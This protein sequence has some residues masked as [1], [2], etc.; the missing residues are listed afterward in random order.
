MLGLASKRKQPCKG[1]AL[2][3][4]AWAALRW[5][6][7]PCGVCSLS[8]RIEQY[9]QL[10]WT[11]LTLLGGLPPSG[12]SEEC[13]SCEATSAA[14]SAL[15][16][17]PGTRRSR[18]GPSPPSRLCLGRGSLPPPLMPLTHA[19]ALLLLLLAAWETAG[20]REGDATERPDRGARE[21]A[22]SGASSGS[23][24][25]LLRA[26]RQLRQARRGGVGLGQPPPVVVL[27]TQ[28]GAIRVKL[29]EGVAPRITALVWQLAAA[30][31]CSTAYTCAFYRW[32]P[33]GCGE[34]PLALVPAPAAL[35]AAPRD[36]DPMSAAAGGGRCRGRGGGGSA[37][38]LAPV[39][40]P[41]R[42]H[43]A[44]L[45][46]CAAGTRRGRSLGRGR[47]TRCCRGACMTWQ[48]RAGLPVSDPPPQAVPWW[49]GRRRC[50][51]RRRARV[52]GRAG[53]LLSAVLPLLPLG[54]PALTP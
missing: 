13:P 25:G 4:R 44:P 36:A 38:R 40:A 30:R 21:G 16:L 17:L 1:V 27:Y 11:R 42:G 37:L 32:G 3:S 28:F 7:L 54:S 29:L 34:P 46:G 48:R 19:C 43:A 18:A 52:F 22:S 39:L 20:A 33:R 35:Q 8:S 53:A 47:L 15:G 41:T 2:A 26:P 51:G 50:S 23:G 24:G 12:G 6:G 5:T 49:F 9:I 14:P 31:N 45:L 10:I